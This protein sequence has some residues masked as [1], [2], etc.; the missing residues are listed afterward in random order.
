MEKLFEYGPALFVIL[1]TLFSLLVVTMILVIVSRVEIFRMKENYDAL[2]EYLGNGESRD[3]LHELTALI[4]G[5]EHD[6]RMREKDIADIFG[7]LSNCIQKVAIVRYNAFHNVGSDLSFSVALLDSEDDGVVLS[8]IYGRDASTT[9]AKPVRAGAS[10]YVLTEEE[11]NAILLAR[12]EYIGRS[13]YGGGGA[14]A[15][16]ADV[17]TGGSERTASDCGGSDSE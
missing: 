5:I 14:G 3:I 9:Y 8:G 15:G 10:S 7:I 17:G 6:G 1:A 12:R 4:R 13:Y 16:S 2:L 11:E